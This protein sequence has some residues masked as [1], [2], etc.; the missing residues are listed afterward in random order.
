MGARLLVGSLGIAIQSDNDLQEHLLD[1]SDRSIE[2]SGD[3]SIELSGDI[4]SK[5]SQDI[6][7]AVDSKLLRDTMLWQNAFMQNDRHIINRLCISW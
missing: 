1:G 7:S 4:G 2:L 5:F 6:A 3:L